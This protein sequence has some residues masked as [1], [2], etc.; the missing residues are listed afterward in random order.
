MN[1]PEVASIYV[2]AVDRENLITRLDPFA[3]GIT[4]WTHLGYE[5]AVSDDLVLQPIVMSVRVL[6]WD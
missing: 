1:F 6:W 3:L 4:F 2:E 5:A